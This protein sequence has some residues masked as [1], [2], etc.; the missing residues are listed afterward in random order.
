MEEP[1]SELTQRLREAGRQE[2][3][4]LVAA[5]R[6][7]LT[8]GEAVQALRNAHVDTE[9]LAQ[10]ARESR[11]LAAGEV[12]RLVALHPRTPEVAAM[13]LIPTLSWPELVALGLEMRIRPTVRRAAD[14]QLLARLPGLAVG[15]KVAIARRADTAL[16]EVLR[17]DP[18]PRVISALLENPRLTEGLVDALAR[19]EGAPPP[20]LELLARDRRWGVRHDLRYVLA[21]NPRTP[22]GAVLPLLPTLRKN[23]LRE[24]AEDRRLAEPVRQRSR[25]L[26]GLH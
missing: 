1:A 14:R 12:R 11:L 24:I 9:A 19:S 3:A 15:E 7:E 2:L 20:I 6:G 8:V 4:D 23:E 18:T 17:H 16:I 26:L 10:I 5:H 22:V 21:R 13:A 25:L